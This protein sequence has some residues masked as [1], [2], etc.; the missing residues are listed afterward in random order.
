MSGQGA[1]ARSA[2]PGIMSPRG[3]TATSSTVEASVTMKTNPY[4]KAAIMEVV[5]NQLRDRNPPETKQTFDRLLAEGHSEAEA[6]RLIGC[7]VVYEIFD[8]MKHG[9]VFDP[10]RYAA[11]LA[12]LPQLPDDC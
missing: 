7:I 2:K 6:R 10:E 3:N 9:R 11:A 8:I 1:I 5:E 12:R 4:L